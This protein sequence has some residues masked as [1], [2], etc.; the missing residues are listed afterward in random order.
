VNLS[1]QQ[2]AVLGVPASVVVPAGASAANIAVDG[3]QLSAAGVGVDATLDGVTL[4]GHV[5]VIDVAQAAQLVDFEPATVSLTANAPLTMAVTL[6]VPAPAGGVTV[7][8]SAT[9]GTLPPTV[10]VAQDQQRAEFVYTQSGTHPTDTVSAT[11]GA[12]T[13]NAVVTLVAAKIVINEVDYDQPGTDSNEFIELYNPDSASA[14]LGTLAVVLINGASGKEYARVPLSGTLLPGGYLIVGSPT[15][16][17]PPG[18]IVFQLGATTNNIQNGDPDGVA[19]VD[20][21]TGKLV[22]ALSYGG[23]ITAATINGLTGTFNLVE[24]NAATAKDSSSVNGSLSRLPNGADVGDAATDWAF[25]KN[26]TPGAAN[27]P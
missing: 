23:A 24:G 11:L 2:P 17:V 6:D 8:L 4:T 13:L 16:A 20:L 1:S 22:D 7:A 9:A 5:R 3:L 26:P 19:L 14:P 18:T 25:S 15:I 10:T 27:V 21:A 12:T